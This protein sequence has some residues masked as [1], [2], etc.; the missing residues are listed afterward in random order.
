MDKQN[1]LYSAY[2]ELADK[3]NWESENYML[4]LKKGGMVVRSK[5]DGQEVNLTY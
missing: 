4:V 5:K 3:G 1:L 2:T